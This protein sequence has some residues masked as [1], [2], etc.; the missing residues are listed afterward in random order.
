[1][2]YF[3]TQDGLGWKN[4]DGI[5][6]ICMNKDESDQLIKEIYSGYCVSHFVACTT[7]HNIARARYYLPTLFTDTHRYVMSFQPCQFFTGM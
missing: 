1:M 2:K 5:I 3:L 7:A 6:L 4:P